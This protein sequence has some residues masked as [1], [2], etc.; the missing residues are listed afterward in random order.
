MYSGTLNNG[1]S[2]GMTEEESK[3]AP[4]EAGTYSV[5]VFYMVGKDAYFGEKEF[6]I[7][8]ADIAD[9]K[10][11]LGDELKDN[12]SE[13]TQE[14]SKVEL[15]GKDIT[16]LCTVSDNKA[17]KYGNYKLTVTVNKDGYNYRGE[18]KVPFTVY[19]DDATLEAAKKVAIEDLEKQYKPDDYSGAAKAAVTAALQKA[20]A[21]I[22]KARTLEEIEQAK[23]DMAQSLSKA[24]RNNTLSVKGRTAQVKF[25]KLKKKTQKLKVSKTITF[26]N[27]GQGKRSY[28]LSSAKKGKKNFKKYFKINKKT[29]Q[30]QIKKKLKKGTYKVKVKVKAAGNAN[31][32]ASSWKTVTIRVKVK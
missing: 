31:Y 13:Q 7:K 30:I 29:G 21:A 19:P 20:K 9:A 5:F 11:T 17:T 10:V 24:K 25:A 6:S 3:T 18:A 8:P 2:Y 23:A 4:T 26:R 22:N 15:D 16:D 28:K 1:E 12:G 14:V 32:K 27:R